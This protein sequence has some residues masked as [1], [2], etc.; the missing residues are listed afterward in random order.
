MVVTMIAATVEGI[1]TAGLR[2]RF[3]LLNK[4]LEALSI[5]RTAR[6]LG[7]LAERPSSQG[8]P[9]M[10]ATWIETEMGEHA[11]SGIR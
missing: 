4:R 8:S 10:G 11:S 5:S 7:Q 3:K 6:Q 1:V 2:N 9:D